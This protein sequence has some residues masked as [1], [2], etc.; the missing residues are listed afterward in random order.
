MRTPDLLIFDC[1]GVL[2]DSEVLA[3][4]ADADCL[5]EIGVALTAEQ[6]MER[7]VGV[8]LLEMLADIGARAGRQL[9]ADLADTMRRRTAE[10]FETGL[11]AITGVDAVL[12]ELCLPR[13]VASGSEPARIRQ[14]LTLAGLL[15]YF[16]PH[17]FS[18]TQVGH[19][20]PAPDLFL[21]AAARMGVAPARCLVIEDSQAGVR[22]ARAAGMA[23]LGFTG[24]SHCRPGHDERL[25]VAGATAVFAD[26]RHL[27]ELLAA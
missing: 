15:H 9:P 11:T 13:C 22:A 27:P 26:M 2:I 14:S 7:Y 1:D 5:A 8:G 4:R 10:V 24:G 16:E 12:S 6:V 17:V 3:C 18:A 23:V 20:K 19:G 21:F 25:S